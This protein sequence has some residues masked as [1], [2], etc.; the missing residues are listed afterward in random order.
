MWTKTATDL[1]PK[2]SS[3]T[4]L[5]CRRI[6]FCLPH[7][8]ELYRGR[9]RYTCPQCGAAEWWLNRF[10]DDALDFDFQDT[11]EK[12]QQLQEHPSR[13]SAPPGPAPTTAHVAPAR[14]QSSP[15]R[16][17]WHLIAANHYPELYR[18]VGPRLAVKRNGQYVEIATKGAPWTLDMPGEITGGSMSP[19]GQRVLLCHREP[20]SS[21]QHLTCHEFGSRPLVIIGPDKAVFSQP[22]FFNESRFVYLLRDSVGTLTMH[23]GAFERQNL[24]H[25]RR[26][27]SLGRAPIGPNFLIPQPG[28]QCALTLR[29][30][31]R[32]R[33]EVV[34]VSLSTG[35]VESLHVLETNIRQLAAA[36]F[37]LELAWI[38]IDGRVCRFS[39]ASGVSHV[40]HSDEGLLGVSDDGQQVAWLHRGRLEVVHLRA[41]TAHQYPAPD[42]GIELQWMGDQGRG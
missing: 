22:R 16:L 40:G 42:G 15:P 17:E 38:T 31:G 25:C 26:I 30:D 18:R 37:G 6:V 7:F 19:S 33:S 34:S 4:C 36:R 10:G 41:G 21:S 14:T 12:R 5:G 27:R 24:I 1:E 11:E 9:T 20:A 2:Q 28:Q 23:E 13:D 39:K 8:T 35:E 29:S 3:A 32:G